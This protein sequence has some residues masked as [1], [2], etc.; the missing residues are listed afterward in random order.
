MSLPFREP[1]NV[2]DL[3]GV[4]ATP[5]PKASMFVAVGDEKAPDNLPGSTGKDPE[6]L[7]TSLGLREKVPVPFKT[8]PVLIGTASFSC[9]TILI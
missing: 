6:L 7:K 1:I 2:G 5:A 8:S 4:L 3:P 9:E